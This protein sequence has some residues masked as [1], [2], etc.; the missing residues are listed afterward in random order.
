MT[1]CGKALL[2]IPKVP[3]PRP[4]RSMATRVRSAGCGGLR[5]WS[6]PCGCG[7]P[8]QWAAR[9][10]ALRLDHILVVWSAWV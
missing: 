4:I 3:L 9:P 8:P 1:L 7:A 10:V 5:L 2:S 6:E